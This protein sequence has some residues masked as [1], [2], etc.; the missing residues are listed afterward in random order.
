MQPRLDAV[1]KYLPSPLDVPPVSG[2]NKDGDTET[3]KTSDDENF[4][5]LVFK[6]AADPFVGNLAYLRVYS[7]VLK[8]GSKVY[9]SAKQKQ[10]KIG[11]ILRMHANK[12]EEIKEVGAGDIAA[13]VGLRFTTTGDTL[14]EIGDSL[15]LESIDFPEPVISIASEPKG[16][17][18]EEKLAESLE[19]IAI[20][21][22]SFRIS[23]NPDTGQ[24]IISGMGELHLEIIVDRLLRE[25][26]VGAN[27]GNPQVAYKETIGIKARAEGVFDHLT[28]GKRQY[29]HV[30]LEMEPLERGAGFEFVVQVKEDEIPK[31]L[32]PAIEKAV[33]DSLGSGGL[34]GFPM[35][36][37]RV[38]LVGGSYH[39]EESTDQAFGVAANMAFRKAA[40]DAQPILLEPV[41]ELEIVAPEN[42]TG[43]VMGDLNA[44]RAK[45]VG[46]ESRGLNL[47]VIKAHVPLSEMFGYSTD[48]RSATQGR[49]SFSM[50]FAAYDV[51]PEQITRQIVQ[52]VRGLL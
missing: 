32:L 18:D 16:K 15:L 45:V 41:M 37:V 31:N 3:R 13:V 51:V 5:A 33:A 2:V 12:R 21:D 36:D 48:L 27:V 28:G 23:T 52:R 47:Q 40:Q 34:I 17:A 20:E 24:T 9:N 4:A 8:L 10:E 14:C 39:E 6:L 22:P 19:K 49:A 26:K 46:I 43:D 1:V 50:Q 35:M 25:F 30:W 29:G 42:Y 7:G 38:S 44:R 11:R